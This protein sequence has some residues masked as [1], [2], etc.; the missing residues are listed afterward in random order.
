LSG[1]YVNDRVTALPTRALA[2]CSSLRSVRFDAVI[3]IG[4]YSLSP[5]GVKMATFPSAT[6]SGTNIF[7]NQTGGRVLD[8]WVATS[9]AGISLNGC[10]T[11][12]NGALVLRSLTL[13]TLDNNWS[14]NFR[15]Y[16]Y[17]PKVMADG[18][19]G[20]AVY[21]SATNWSNYAGRFRYIE[22]YTVDG[23]LYGELD[24]EKMGVSI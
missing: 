2:G 5:S 13:C 1:D 7:R 20:I 11:M 10:G 15:P 4:D 19:D 12:N 23:T 14:I 3:T 24:L 16:F 22:D 17:V 8:L 9:F 18:S 21:E 6:T